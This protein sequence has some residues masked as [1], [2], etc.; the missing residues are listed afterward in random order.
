MSD[1]SAL[2]IRCPQCRR[3]GTWFA[4][5]WGP[6]CSERCR[7]LD[8]GRWFDEEQRISRELRPGDFEGFD[9]LPPGPD[10]DRREE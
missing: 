8:L 6:F 10:L 9:E 4:G 2:R 7:L 1:D 3:Q 5:R